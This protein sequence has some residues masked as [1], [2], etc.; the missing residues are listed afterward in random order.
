MIA[1]YPLGNACAVPPK[2]PVATPMI[3]IIAVLIKSALV[4]K[5]MG[6]IIADSDL[7]TV[8]PFVS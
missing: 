5:D 2:E 3:K 8:V 6:L 1:G 4:R 7:A